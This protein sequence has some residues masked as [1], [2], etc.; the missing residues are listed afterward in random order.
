M[1]DCGSLEFAQARLQ[2]RHGQ[3][4]GDAA[5]QRLETAR[6]FGALLEVARRTVLRPWLVG[7]GTPASAH[8][9]EAALRT[10]WRK[11][12]AEIAG[13][14]PVA[15]QPAVLWCT[16]LA[17]LP[18]L[19]H[20]ARGGEPLPWMLDD[21][22]VRTLCSAPPGQRAATV[23][24]GRF[25]P[26]AAAWSEPAS[27]AQAWHAAWERRLPQRTRDA[28]D[29]LNQ[30]ASALLA[31]GRAFATAPPGTGA[32]LRRALQA[33]LSLL[34]RRTTL[35]PAAVFIHVALCALDFERLRG[36]LL[37]RAL[38]PKGQVA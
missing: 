28:E 1:I 7:I 38:F 12:V 31:H 23:A 27:L 36:E 15:W 30:V 19:Q 4:A 9:I 16:A 17:D 5:W 35:E 2:A 26:L 13:W 18:V 8:Q 37:R 14:M 33:R 34:L 3:R 11:A 29:G 6:E 21:P 25:A 20:L 24:A 32:L 10:H 22:D